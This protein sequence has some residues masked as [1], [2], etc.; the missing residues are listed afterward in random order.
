MKALFFSWTI[1]C[2]LK[3]RPMEI[4]EKMTSGAS[5]GYV[6]RT[7]KKWSEKEPGILIEGEFICIFKNM[8]KRVAI[9][10]K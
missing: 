10:L 7:G 4:L 3:Y 1:G 6:C 2:L 8:H 9:H 5:D